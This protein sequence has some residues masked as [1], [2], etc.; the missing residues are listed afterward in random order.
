MCY[1]YDNNNN[2]KQYG[3]ITFFYILLRNPFDS[4]SIFGT[5]GLWVLCQVRFSKLTGHQHSF[6]EILTADALIQDRTKFH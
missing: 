1:V 3:N 2:R 5:T 4:G 6:A